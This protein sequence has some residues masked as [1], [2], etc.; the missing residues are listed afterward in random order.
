MKFTVVSLMPELVRSA[1]KTGL[2][3]QAI[4][5]GL[6]GLDAINPREFG[7]GSHRAVDDRVFGG[8][9]GMLMQPEPLAKCLDQI[10]SDYAQTEKPRLIHLSP[11]GEL[12][13]DRMA[14]DMADSARDFVLISSRYA[15]VDQRFLDEYDVQEISIGDYVLS[16]GELPSC[17]LIEA[18]ARHV[19]GVLGNSASSAKDSFHD[20]LLEGPQY[21]RPKAWRDREVP[22]VLLCGDQKLI[23]YY[24][25][26]QALKVTAERRPELLA[27]FGFD[28]AQEIVSEIVGKL[29]AVVREPGLSA[30]RKSAVLELE[31]VARDVGRVV[32]Q[33]MPKAGGQLKAPEKKL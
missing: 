24:E 4:A 15:G 2:V 9:D 25:R 23:S 32:V 31:E 11:R 1:F 14:R 30:V 17:I 33:V 20:G 8:S 10:L 19:P 26:L 18:I 13:T 7:E 12:F 29:S 27:A 16:G 22:G 3:G 5:K 28:Q 6:V 21:T